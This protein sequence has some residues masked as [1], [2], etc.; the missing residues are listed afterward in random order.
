MAIKTV[1]FNEG[2]PWLA[3]FG[4]RLSEHCQQTGKDENDLDH[5]CYLSLIKEWYGYDVKVDPLGVSVTL[6]MEEKD[7]TMFQ[8]RWGK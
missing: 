6:A 1:R 2:H 8:L 4:R 3:D 7:L 5:D